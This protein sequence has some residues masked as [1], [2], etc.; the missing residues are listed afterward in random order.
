MTL[1][2]K[3]GSD[4]SKK[5]EDINNKLEDLKK[6]KDLQQEKRENLLN[7]IGIDSYQKLVELHSKII[8]TPTY[9]KY[10]N[11]IE[12]GD[13]VNLID[14]DQTIYNDIYMEDAMHSYYG[15]SEVRIILEIIMEK[16]G[17]IANINNMDD[18]EI[19]V[20]LGYQI[21]GYTLGNQFSLNEDGNITTEL[22]CKKDSVK[23][24]LK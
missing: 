4:M 1:L 13:V 7:E 18:Y 12:I 3:E 5:L 10:P 22:R 20:S 15:C 6:L 16:D 2:V 19:L 24:L 9:N 14:E 23:T 21:K 17:I 8:L 11:T